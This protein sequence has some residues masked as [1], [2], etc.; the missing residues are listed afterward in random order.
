MK[1][2]APLI[3][4]LIAPLTF[5]EWN[6]SP[7]SAVKFL[8]TKNTNITEVHEF[9]KLSGKVSDEGEAEVTI[10]LASADT[11]IAIRNE[12]MQS[13]LFNV[14]EYAQA[15]VSAELPDTLML[16]LSNGETAI[17][18]LPMTLEL[19][20]VEKEIEA[21][22]LATAGADGHVIVT[23]RS[24]VLIKADVWD[25]AD[26]IDALREVAGLDRIS[27]TVPVTFTLLF[28]PASK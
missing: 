17:S 8:S 27:T 22:V 26:G 28:T 10:D 3:L 25:L 13:M 12:R 5:A 2:I 24:P 16:A 6:L 11:G 19:H 1:L 9:T 21:D 23:T 7:D 4:T 15:R 14:S 18:T 20:G